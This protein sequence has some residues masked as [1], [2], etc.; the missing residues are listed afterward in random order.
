MKKVISVSAAGVVTFVKDDTFAGLEMRGD[1]TV[2]R[3]SHVM[4]VNPIK[5]ILF[6]ILRR[7]VRDTCPLAEWS[8]RWRGDW[9]VDLSPSGGP[10]LGPFAS[11]RQ[12]IDQEVEWLT[13]YGLRETS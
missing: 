6:R 9:Q 5:R 3:A 10:P 11:R 4:P 2:R 1:A 7:S 12:A 13:V 8:R